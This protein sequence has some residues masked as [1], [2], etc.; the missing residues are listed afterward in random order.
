MS[1]LKYIYFTQFLYFLNIFDNK[2]M[3]VI[4]KKKTNKLIY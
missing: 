2:E 1:F 3:Y 4:I